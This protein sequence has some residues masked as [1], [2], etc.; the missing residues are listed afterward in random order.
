MF[1]T[2]PDAE[3]KQVRTYRMP[4]RLIRCIEEK[5][6]ELGI[7]PHACGLKLLDEACRGERRQPG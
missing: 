6:R 7:S 1:Q 2:K 4:V 3:L 5:A